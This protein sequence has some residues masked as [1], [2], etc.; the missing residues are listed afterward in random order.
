[1][2]SVRVDRWLCAARL[3]KSRSQA[4]QSCT[5]GH[6]QVND[7]NVKPHQVVRVGDSIRVKRGERLWVVEVRAL[8]E[9]RQSPV[10]ARELYED[11]SPPP[12]SRKEREAQRDPGAGRP[13]K[14]DRRLL[15]RL[16]G[17]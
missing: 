15:R 2:D 1:M 12:P 6:V 16:R 3:F 11:H 17:R 5:G 14:R 7:H 8:A 9:K 4:Q 10:A 13:S